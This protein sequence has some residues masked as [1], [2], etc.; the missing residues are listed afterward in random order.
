M[1]GEMVYKGKVKEV[2]TTEDPDIIES[3]T[4]P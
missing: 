2:W 3:G 4:Q 1:T